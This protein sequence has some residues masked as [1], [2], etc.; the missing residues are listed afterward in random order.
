M[1]RSSLGV[2]ACVAGLALVSRA[3]FF[4]FNIGGGMP[5]PA[6]VKGQVRLEPA[7][8]GGGIP[9]SGVCT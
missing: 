2:V 9:G 5:P 4:N 7:P 1:S 8:A 6:A 3:Q